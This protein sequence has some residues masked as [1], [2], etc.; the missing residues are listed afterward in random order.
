MVKSDDIRRKAG[1]LE[2]SGGIWW[3]G[4]EP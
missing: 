2:G 1:G 4:G 3:A